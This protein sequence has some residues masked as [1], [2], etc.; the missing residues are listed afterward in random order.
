[1]W[2]DINP[3]S[4]NV[5]LELN[6]RLQHSLTWTSLT[7]GVKNLQHSP[8]LVEILLDSLRRIPLSQSTCPVLL[9][10]LLLEN[11]AAHLGSTLRKSG[12]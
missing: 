11:S 8:I 9:M 12:A 5:S 1:M 2:N 6:N 4:S 3:K 10:I 7:P